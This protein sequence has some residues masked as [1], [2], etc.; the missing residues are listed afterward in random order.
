MAKS[1]STLDIEWEVDLEEMF[2]RKIDNAALRERIGQE[3]IARVQKRTL[4]GID[5][6]GKGFKGYS[7]SYKEQT[8]K[9]NPPDLA[10]SGRMLQRMRVIDSEPE[11]LTISW[12]EGLKKI[13]LRAENHIHGVTLPRRDFLGLPDKE[14][15]SV[16]VEFEDEVEDG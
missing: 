15:R 4:S 2:G 5:K 14:I 12:S 1:N 6:R 10:V 3:L 7:K 16:V 8:G 9:G 11:G 13:R